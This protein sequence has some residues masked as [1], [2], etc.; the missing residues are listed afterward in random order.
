MENRSNSPHKS[1]GGPKRIWHACHYSYDGIVAAC[2]MEAAFRQLLLLALVLIPLAVF[3][4]VGRLERILMLCSILLS[5]IIELLNSAIEAAVDRV[6]L[7]THPLSKQA[8]D[9]GSAAQ[10][11]G[12]INIA[13]VWGM[14]LFG[15]LGS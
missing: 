3:L 13:V 1:R 14:V 5:L 4:P 6:S 8:K 11:L 9:M 15:T 12:L 2:R 7:D 10:T